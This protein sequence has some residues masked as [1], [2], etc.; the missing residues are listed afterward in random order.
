MKDKS[1]RS[2]LH[3]SLS[4]HTRTH[5]GIRSVNKSHIKAKLKSHR[6]KADMLL[7]GLDCELS[8]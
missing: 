6:R 7:P 1:T 3:D 8:S 4:H 5:G 2:R